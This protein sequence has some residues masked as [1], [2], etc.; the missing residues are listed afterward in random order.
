MSKVP[1][2]YL[3]EGLILNSDS[4]SNNFSDG[5]DI[6]RLL[7]V[8]KSSILIAIIVFPLVFAISFLY[9]RYTKPMFQSESVIKLKQK[10]ESQVLGLKMGGQNMNSIA[11]LSGEIE[12]IKS[13]LIFDKLI[14]KLGLELS[15]YEYGKILNDEKFKTNAFYVEFENDE[16][17]VAF[18]NPIDV[19]F[20][21]MSSFVVSLKFKEATIEV[22]GQVGKT[23]DL[24]G[25]RFVV[26]RSPSFTEEN[27]KV[28]YFFKV[29]SNSALY[30]YIRNNL[31]VVILNP[32]ANTIQL[33]FQ[34]HNSLK[35][36]CII[37][38]IDS[39]YLESTLESK[40][41]EQ[42]QV[43]SYINDQLDNTAKSL[44]SSEIQLEDFVK[45]S[46][47]NNPNS[48]F[49]L[50][51]TKLDLL[52]ED[53]TALK[54]ESEL[55]DGI[56]K[57][58]VADTGHTFISS[59]TSLNNSQIKD[60]INA[61]NIAYKDLSK[62]RA[63]LSVNTLAY[64]QKVNEVQE[65]ESSL[66]EY[67][68]ENRKVLLE[69]TY[70]LNEE[71]QKLHDDFLGLPSK[72]TELTRLKRFY[73]L[74]E[75]FYLLLIEKRVEYGILKAGAVPEFI[76]L[77]AARAPGAL[78]YPIKLSV[79]SISLFLSLII[80]SVVIGFKYVLHNKIITVNDLE[81][82][83]KAPVLGMIP[84]FIAEQLIYSSL[85]IDR[86][87]KSAVTEALRSIRTNLDFISPGST[88]KMITVTSTISGEGKTFVAINLAGILAMSGKKAI[89]IDL[90]MRKPKLHLGFDVENDIGMST[91][92]IKKHGLDECIKKSKLENL[93]MICAG[94]LPPNPSEL[95]MLPVFDDVIKELYEKYDVVI[96]DTP[97][98]GLVTDGL[99]VMK[100]ADIPLYVVRSGYSL[101]RVDQNINNLYDSGRFKNMSVILNAVESV[102]GYGY[103]Y[104]YGDNGSYYEEGK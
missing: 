55:L 33:T 93:D 45:Q 31:N 100:K 6:I 56:R 71:I 62:L 64:K 3:S 30:N 90:D 69:K 39:I 14:E 13:Q 5:F 23:V 32:S 8:L 89:V 24:N 44:E 72:N 85:V 35:A 87:P 101:R 2:D 11:A 65:L 82:S 47:T 91:L 52:Y 54:I 22:V 7:H 28:P 63:T 80:V 96:V 10:S 19:T 98:V 81:K 68:F 46:G 99:L 40:R 29:H 36:A 38:S 48:D 34:D 4:N 58:L 25:F 78:V 75:K 53:K 9:L 79:Y 103:G 70:A 97:P 76:I 66:L 20:N 50:I 104:G 27:I 15:Y 1:K 74:W 95:I 18:D 67:V 83:L 73:D 37:N 92:L 86:F 21:S 12:I 60:G 57:S 59:I 26:R 102:G 42:E 43:I 61:L 88:K 17:N 41:L 84:K 77:S 49:G 16:N 94:P 51:K